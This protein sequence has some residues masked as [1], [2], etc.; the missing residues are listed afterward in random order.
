[1]DSNF[2]KYIR[3]INQTGLQQSEIELIK[4]ELHKS[5]AILSSEEQKYAKIILHDIESGD[6]DYSEGTSLRDYINQYMKEAKN[7]QIHTVAEIF[8]LDESKLRDLIN[9]HVNNIT[10][11]EFGRFDNL[12]ATVDKKAAKEY[13][14][15]REGVKLS[16]PKVNI[17]ISK[18]LNHFIIEGG[19]EMNK[20]EDED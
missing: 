19:F 10:V 11:N 9:A 17:R 12:V 8:K 4:N 18:F 5:F 14:E 20:T 1:M 2:K 13:F 15:S 16:P 3:A 7:D 6:L